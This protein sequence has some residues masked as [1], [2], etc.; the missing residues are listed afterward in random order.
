MRTNNRIRGRRLAIVLVTAVFT[1]AV[2]STGYPAVY[3]DTSAKSVNLE[4]AME[5]YGVPSDRVIEARSTDDLMA[6][7]ENAGSMAAP[8]E[9]AIVYLPSGEYRLCGHIDVP[10][11]TVLVADD[12][13]LIIASNDYASGDNYL[14]RLSGSMYGGIY[15][16]NYKNKTTIR[17]LKNGSFSNGNG[18]IEYL[19]V[20][21]SSRYGI[22]AQ[23]SKKSKINGCTVT[24]CK[25]SGISVLKPSSD[26][27]AGATQ[28]ES[29]TNSDIS[30]NGTKGEG[31]GINLSFADVGTIDRCTI[32]SNADK[33]VST[34]SD[35]RSGCHIGTIKNCT[36]K[37][38]V[39]NGVHIKPNCRLDHFVKN[40]L[41]G[42]DDG[43]IAAAI[44]KEGTKGKSIIKDVSKNT[45]KTS[46]T[47]QI[48]AQGSGASITIG[49]GNKILSGKTYGILAFKYGKVT[50]SGSNNIIKGNYKGIG[51]QT[52]G[53][54]KISGKK[55]QIIKNKNRGVHAI[56]KGVISISG[57]SNK[58]SGNKKGAVY[59]ASGAKVTLK[60]V[61]ISGK[62]YKSGGKVIKK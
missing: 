17:L 31:A 1:L 43:I 29:I 23:G 6:A 9:K 30:N 51:A 40:T 46:K 44:T 47:P 56:K 59:C 8:A 52:H 7:L 48:E 13:S 33:A 16:S 38:N 54:I 11:N 50:I 22:V 45:F 58:I 26:T 55:N 34:N 37:N 41:V 49:S 15:D 12:D 2:I 28:I 5:E 57:S 27:A 3:A 60:K 10:E 20:R 18:Q 61:K 35:S 42:N 53:S 62:I 24:K 4:T 39:N 36:I 19:T 21:K 32:S 14:V 25:A